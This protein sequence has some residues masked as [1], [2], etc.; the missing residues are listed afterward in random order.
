MNLA[1]DRDAT[2]LFESHHLLSPRLKMEKILS[3]Y[4]VVEKGVANDLKLLDKRDDGA[5]YE[6]TNY[7]SDPFMNDIKQVLIDY[8]Q[9]IARQRG[10]TLYQ[11]SK[12]TPRRLF[13]IGILFIT[14]LATIPSYIN[15]KYWTLFV[16]P[17][18]AWVCSVNYW[19]DC[20]HFS[21]SSDWRIN[22]WLPY[23]MPL[24]CSPWMWYHQ[25]VIGHHAYTNIGYK[26]P[27]LA[28]AP[29]LLREH[30]SI[31][32][33]PLHQTQ[34]TLRRITSVWSIAV[35]MGLNI[36]S[37]L[38]ANLKL[39]YNNVVPYI[40][41]SQPRMIA[42]IVGR[43]YYFY[44]TFFWPFLVFPPSKALLWAIIPNVMYSL[45]FMINSQINHLTDE[46]SDAYDTNFFKHQVVTAQNFG[47]H[48]WFCGFYSGHLN[49]QIEHHLFPNVNHCHLR[50]LA[51]MVEK[52]CMKHNVPY[53]KAKGYVDAFQKHFHHTKEMSKRQ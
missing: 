31:S 16:T 6:W 26:D 40:K 29:Q 30:K 35:G 4:K 12:A 17:Q 45:T 28:H 25:H 44:M 19:H 34:G 51:P 14:F 52:V 47:I 48:S 3:K 32:W 33:K 18:L 7:D 5:H 15:G 27:D 20:L 36:F 46:C 50:H 39:S 13:M 37:D 22:A 8:L 24:L 10:C 38:R 42:H 41:L 49:L 2:A 21:L 1:K 43:F 11:A 53:H 9:P 23:V